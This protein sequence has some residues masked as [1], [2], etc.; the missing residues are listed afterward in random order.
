MSRNEVGQHHGRCFR[1]L[2]HIR[3]WADSF[4]SGGSADLLAI[5]IVPSL[6]G[7]HLAEFATKEIMFSFALKKIHMWWER[8]VDNQVVAYLVREAELY[9]GAGDAYGQLSTPY[10]RSSLE[11]AGEL[12]RSAVDI[13]QRLERLERAKLVERPGRLSDA[14][15]ATEHERRDKLR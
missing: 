15:T 11:I 6:V 1:L 7:L 4:R 13:R 12:N 9:P 3:L 5:R 2:G 10:Y 8:Q 14:W